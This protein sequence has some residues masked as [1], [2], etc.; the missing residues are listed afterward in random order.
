M[1]DDKK[2][3]LERYSDMVDRGEIQPDPAQSFVAHTLEELYLRIIDPGFFTRL[4]HSRQWVRRF[5]ARSVSHHDQGIYLWGD[6]GRGKSMLMD[7]F[8]LSLPFEEK[9]RVHFHSFMLEVHARIHALRQDGGS[10]RD[11]LLIVAAEQAEKYRVLCFDEFQVH[12]IADAM[13]LSRLF[14]AMFAKG[15]VILFTSNRIPDDLYKNGLQRGRFLPFI[16]LLK[17]RVKVVELSAQEDYRRSRM[18]SLHEVYCYPLG[19]QADRFIRSTFAALLSGGKA[20]PLEVTVQGRTVHVTQ[21][22]RDIAVFSFDELCARPMGASDY[23]ALAGLFRIF[24]ITDIPQMGPEHR[25]EAK[26]FTTL[27][28]VLYEERS[29]L[30]CTAAV[31]AEELYAMGDGSFE[32]ERAVSRLIEMQSADY[33]GASQGSLR[34]VS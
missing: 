9:R 5:F 25:N 17:E 27:I 18:A 15:M 22:C 2:T 10:H 28:D 23:L 20:G 1:A 26:R 30:I 32:F 19:A 3:P 6:V 21:A 33:L 29:L 14:T 11:P 34:A 13:I 24:L 7:L 16:E 12:D 4:R 31:P 8:F